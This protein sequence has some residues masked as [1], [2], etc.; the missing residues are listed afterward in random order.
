MHGPLLTDAVWKGG[1]VRVGLHTPLQI[2]APHAVGLGAVV[3][4]A[5]TVTWGAAL[6]RRQRVTGV[7]QW[8]H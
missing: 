8:G 7:V 2:C 4:G 6:G 1:S 3:T 5:V